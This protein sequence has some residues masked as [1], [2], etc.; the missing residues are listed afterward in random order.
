M[1]PMEDDEFSIAERVDERAFFCMRWPRVIVLCWWCLA[2]ALFTSGCSKG[3]DA[4][5]GWVG[6]QRNELVQTWGA[7][8]EETPLPDGGKL[9][10]YR[11]NWDNGYERRTCER[12]F[13][14]DVRGV[15]RSSSSSGC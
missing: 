4:T 2:M 6:H 7:P 1:R 15:I 12:M 11:N 14:I 3:D 8:A 5:R 13:V 9:V 10:L